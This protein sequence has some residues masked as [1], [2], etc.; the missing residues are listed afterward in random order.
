ME[1][2]ALSF[3]GFF[4]I[5]IGLLPAIL[6]PIEYPLFSPGA[7]FLN[8]FGLTL[9]ITAHSPRCKPLLCLM[10]K[11]AKAGEDALTGI[12]KAVEDAILEEEIKASE[13]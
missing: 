6:S 9:V 4:F 13:S 5:T 7:I 10:K 11:C 2:F 8:V 12:I 1:T 3:F